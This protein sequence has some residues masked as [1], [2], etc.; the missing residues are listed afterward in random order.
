MR[1]GRY[2]LGVRTRILGGDANWLL[3]M[4]RGDELPP[5]QQRLNPLAAAARFLW[6]FGPWTIEDT[7]HL[8]D[9]KPTLADWK[10]MLRRLRG[11]GGT[12]ELIDNPDAPAEGGA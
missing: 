6:N 9:V 11:G 7:Y 8:G 5:D 10:M 2:R 1:P 4:I 3:G 12:V